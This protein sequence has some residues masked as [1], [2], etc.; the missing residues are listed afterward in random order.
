M[1]LLLHEGLV[2]RLFGRF[3]RSAV[4]ALGCRAQQS[5][6]SQPCAVCSGSPAHDVIRQLMCDRLE[7][8]WGAANAR[9]CR[10]ED[11]VPPVKTGE[12]AMTT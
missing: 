7:V 5:C 9:I 12:R 2:V 3:P 4:S 10:V 6:R 1:W 11:V 8:W